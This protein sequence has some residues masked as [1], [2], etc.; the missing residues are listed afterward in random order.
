MKFFQRLSNL[1]QSSLIDKYL[2][3]DRNAE[4]RIMSV[5]RKTTASESINSF[6]EAV[7]VFK[8][9]T[10]PPS[11]LTISSVGMKIDGRSS[12]FDLWWFPCDRDNFFAVDTKDENFVASTVN[13]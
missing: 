9:S 11:A 3:P 1:D 4:M 12:V 5:D 13:S 8:D 2:F 6:F 7:G 10:S